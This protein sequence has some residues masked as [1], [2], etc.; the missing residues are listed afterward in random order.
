MNDG[1]ADG[2]TDGPTDKASY[3]DERMH[4]KAES[5]SAFE[6]PHSVES[7]ICCH[8]QNS[9]HNFSHDLLLL[10]SNNTPRAKMLECN[11][12]VPC[13]ATKRV[14]RQG[15]KELRA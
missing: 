4:L 14:P 7:K 9:F 1:R 5:Y 12:I 10:G 3:R 15:Q 2:P 8:E 6:P 11:N 13:R